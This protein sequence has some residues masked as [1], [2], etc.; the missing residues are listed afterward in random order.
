MRCPFCSEN[1]DRVVDSRESRDGVTIRRRRE[2]LSCGRRFTSYEQIEDIP[3][4]V[5]KHDGTREEFSRKKLLGGL[6]KACEKRPIPLK[7][8]EG[9]VDEAEGMLQDREDREISTTEIGAFVMEKL[10][11]LDQVAYVRFASVYRRFEDID[12]FMD[13]VRS[14]LQPGK[15]REV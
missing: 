14:L 10:R 6:L 12:A 2:C 4:M 11:E 13:V 1:H 7:K 15:E 3:Y 5:V 8:L 9:I